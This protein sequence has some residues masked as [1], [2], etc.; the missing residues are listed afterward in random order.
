M[1]ATSVSTVFEESDHLVKVLPACRG[2][3]LFRT[4]KGYLCLGPTG[5]ALGAE[6]VI[7]EGTTTPFLFRKT[8]SKAMASGTRGILVG[9]CYVM[10]L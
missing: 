9:E 10:G 4:Q 6:V 1:E 3:R 7:I 8:E 5:L 2:R